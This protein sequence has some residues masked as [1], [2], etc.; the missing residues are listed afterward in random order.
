[1]K[2]YHVMIDGR[3]FFDHS[4]KGDPGTHGNI[5]KTEPGQWD[6]TQLVVC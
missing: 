4:V 1:M 5:R 6:I 3:N 2:D